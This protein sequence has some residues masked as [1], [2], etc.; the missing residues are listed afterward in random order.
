MIEMQKAA[1]EQSTHYK[2]KEPR[3]EGRLEKV[4]EGLNFIVRYPLDPE[5]AERT[6]KNVTQL[7]LDIFEGEPNV[8]RINNNLPKIRQH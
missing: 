3:P 5:Q 6:D 4:A 1:L 2:V 8:E 7:I